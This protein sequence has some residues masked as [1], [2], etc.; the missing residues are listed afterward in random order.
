MVSLN[1]IP[2]EIRITLLQR[3]V[4]LTK[5]FVAVL[6]KDNLSAMTDFKG[7]VGEQILGAFAVDGEDQRLKCAFKFLS[8]L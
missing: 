2:R 7:Q 6:S 3:A 5:M 4:S 8:V 1:T